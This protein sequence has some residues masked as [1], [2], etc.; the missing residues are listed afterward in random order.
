MNG[1]LNIHGNIFSRRIQRLNSTV[2][3]KNQK[4]NTTAF[5]NT[6][7]TPTLECARSFGELA[8]GHWGGCGS[9]NH[10]VRAA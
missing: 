2:L 1:L 9:R 4:K 3:S 6:S 10:W 8:R 7:H 5:Y